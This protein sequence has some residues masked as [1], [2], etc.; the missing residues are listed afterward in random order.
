MVMLHLDLGAERW[1]RTE[2]L[3]LISKNSIN[4][5]YKVYNDD[6]NLNL[7]TVDHK[8]VKRHVHATDRA[9]V[10]VINV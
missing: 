8:W 9:T 7:I 3:N 4:G 6:G 5:A 1:K 2:A 10:D